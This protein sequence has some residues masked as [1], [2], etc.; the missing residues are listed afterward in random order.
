MTTTPATVLD[1]IGANVHRIRTQRGMTQE[2][3]AEAAG[4]STGFIKKLERGKTNVGVIALVQIANA[5]EVSPAS[6]FRKAT[7]PE[8]KRGRPPKTPK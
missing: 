4:V 8:V 1:Y 5:L 6:L 3:L 2:E 7:L